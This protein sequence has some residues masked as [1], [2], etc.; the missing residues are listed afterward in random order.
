MDG[1]EKNNNNK[2]KAGAGD[3][4]F[5]KQREGTKWNKIHNTYINKGMNG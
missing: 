3:V 4:T 1:T 2:K 5:D